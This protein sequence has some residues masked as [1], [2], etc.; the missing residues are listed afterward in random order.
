MELSFEN[1]HVVAIV[2][3]MVALLFCKQVLECLHSMLAM[4]HTCASSTC[5]F[6][7]GQQELLRGGLTAALLT[8]SV[9][10]PIIFVLVNVAGNALRGSQAFWTVNFVHIELNA[11][12]FPHRHSQTETL[13]RPLAQSV[14]V[15]TTQVDGLLLV[16]PFA[17]CAFCTTNTWFGM[18]ANGDFSC[19]PMWDSDLFQSRRMQL[20]ESLYALETCL[21]LFVL[22]S[23][24]ADPSQLEYTLVS[25]L[26]ATFILM[27]FSAQSRCKSTSDR[28][29]ESVISIFLFAALN[30]LLSAFVTQHWTAGCPVKIFSACALAMTTILLAGMHMGVT[31]DTRAGHVILFRTLLSCACSVYFAVLL[32]VDANSLS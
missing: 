14:A 1:H 22:L 16:M 20:Y 5:C 30:T 15:S 31:E 21:L 9:C 23:L 13:R 6:H 10:Q 27:Y 12:A 29:S 3:F 8:F 17:L 2:V 7:Y 11:S 24:T 18:K 19:D 32:A 25:A 4:W 26:L 28:A